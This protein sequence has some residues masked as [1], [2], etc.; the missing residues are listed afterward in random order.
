M[1]P[2]EFAITLFCG[3]VL[4]VSV[5]TIY[6]ALVAAE[7]ADQWLERHQ[8]SDPCEDGN[9]PAPGTLTHTIKKL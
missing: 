5:L 3:A 4:G 1:T 6:G 9:K 8:P 7:D 2:F